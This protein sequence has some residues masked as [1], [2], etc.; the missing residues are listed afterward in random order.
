[1]AEL[2]AATAGPLGEG[3]LQAFMSDHAGAPHS[4]CGHGAPGL[5]TI[6]ACVLNPAEGRLW[7]SRGNPCDAGYRC[8]GLRGGPP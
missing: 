3:E 5:Q 8:Y 2:A 1:M 7:A 4:I 6:A